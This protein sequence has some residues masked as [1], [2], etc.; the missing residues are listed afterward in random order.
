M[1]KVIPSFF[2]SKSWKRLEKELGK[3]PKVEVTP[4]NFNNPEEKKKAKIMS[5][6]LNYAFKT[7]ANDITTKYFAHL[8]REQKEYLRE[9]LYGTTKSFDAMEKMAKVLGKRG[10]E[11]TKAKLGIKHFKRISKLGVKARHEKGEFAYLNRI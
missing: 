5:K 3:I 1:T 4:I 11:V 10:G 2:K 7:N 9:L 8:R 6:L